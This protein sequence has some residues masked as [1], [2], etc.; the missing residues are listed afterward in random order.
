MFQNIVPTIVRRVATI[1]GFALIISVQ[2]FAQEPNAKPI[3][4]PEVIEKSVSVATDAEPAKEIVLKEVDR[5]LMA[6]NLKAPIKFDRKSFAKFGYS[7]ETKKQQ[8]TVDEDE[9]MMGVMGAGTDKLKL[10]GHVGFVVPITS[11]GGGA[12]TSILRDRFVFGF[13][14]GLTVKTKHNIA[15]D[16]E[17]IPTFNTGNDFVLTIHPGI[18]FGFKKS[19]VI[20]VRAA[21]DAGAA[22]FGF[23]P[24]IARG[25]RIN[26]KLG[27]FI[28]ADFPVRSNYRPYGDRFASFAIAAHSGIT[29]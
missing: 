13:P 2:T 17:F 15:V 5:A 24:L 9:K 6:E 14:V 20:G 25:F 22:S 10:G 1:L 11:R 19:Y 27:W 26:D 18:L 23:T 7:R 21:Y 8:L 4:S 28:E 16:F 12:T 29:F 3:T